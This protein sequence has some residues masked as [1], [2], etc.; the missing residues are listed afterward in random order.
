MAWEVH[1]AFMYCCLI[2]KVM[3]VAFLDS[4]H[5][6]A[7]V[8]SVANITYQNV[9]AVTEGGVLI[10]GS[11]ESPIRDVSIHNISLDFY[12]L[13]NVPGGF[14]DLRPSG[15]GAVAGFARNG[16]VTGVKDN[17]FYLENAQDVSITAAEARGFLT[18]WSLLLAAVKKCQA[19][20]KLLCCASAAACAF[21]KR[22]SRSM[23]ELQ[24]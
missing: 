13:T 1:V 9:R 6:C 11:P 12:P 22:I 10:N 16:F 2:K 15:N 14:H 17:A 5:S 3:Q 19:E 23:R 21:C 20:K 18:A 4:P 24:R 8:G 7:Q